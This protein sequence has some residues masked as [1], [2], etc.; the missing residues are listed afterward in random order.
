[1]VRELERKH[2]GAEFPE[3]APAANPVF[4]RTYSRRQQ[5]EG[6]RE[7][8]V[9]VCDRT[10]KGLVEL[11][12]LTHDEAVILERMQRNLK[13]LPSG[14][15]LWVGGTNWLTQPKNFSGAYNCTSTNVV[16]WSAFGLMMDLAMMGCGTGAILEPKY[17]N[18][19][20]T[21]RN[22]LKVTIRGNI[23]KTI[24]NERREF[25]ETKIE[26]DRTTIYVGDSRQGWVQS[27]QTLLELSTDER[28]TEE[29]EVIVDISDIR[30]AGEPLQGFGGMANPVKLP[31][32]YQRCAAILN[33]AVGRKLTSVECCLLIDEAAVTIVAGNIRR[34][35]AYG[36]RVS[37]IDGMKPIQDIQVGD[38]VL[39]SSG[40]YRPVVNKFIQGKQKVVEIRT[41]ITS[42]RCTAN[43]RVAVYDGL[44][45]YKWK[46]A[47]QLQ[48]K[49]RLISVPH[50]K[51]ADC[52]NI[53][54]AWLSGFYIGDGYANRRHTG[55][56]E[57][58]FALSK[59]RLEGKLGEK[60]LRIL[61][62]LG[63][64]PTIAYS[65][66]G[67]HGFIK[68]YRKE[69]AEELLKYKQPWECPVIPEFI[70]K[71]SRDI[72]AAF[73]AGLSDADGTPSRNV[74]V[75]SNKLEFLRQV[76]KL[77]LSLGIA[78]TLH[79]RKPRTIEGREKVYEGCHWIHI[80]GLQ[81]QAVVVGLIN[82]FAVRN[83]F[84][85]KLAKKN[86]LTLPYQYVK[87]LAATGWKPET[88]YSA[89]TIWVDPKSRPGYFR[90]A[91]F[92]TLIAEDLVNPHWLPIEVQFVAPA[93][94]A[95]T[96]D[97]EVEGDHEFIADGLLVHNSAGMRQGVSEDTAFADAKEN[98]WQQGEDGNWRIDPE[99]DALRMA[100]HTRVF[101]QKPTLEECVNAV[102]KQ[103][104][105]GE[106]AIQWAG[107]AVA[108]ANIDLL[109]TQELK[110]DFL[111]A[112]QQGK[113][114]YWLKEKY[115]YLD[116]SEIEHRLARAGLNPCGN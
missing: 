115:S 86:G 26:G 35:I 30:K 9:E 50:K 48:P 18:Q 4:F 10:L 47:G 75:N 101:H 80:Q 73:L 1:M 97:I 52:A 87:E 103:Y 81:S 37:A 60:C 70:W 43:H 67:N 94:Q 49:D 27:Y 79:E 77:A 93:G 15:W 36:T 106:G 2:L 39:T 65:S 44:R 45:S 113:G 78:T 31:E 12:K 3:T 23:G 34:C 98:L 108:R 88:L 54:Y 110:T 19:L 56:S 114:A 91:N 55:Q 62:N 16:D 29:V 13:A 90:D 63:Y 76:Q 41:P 51:G 22:R 61:Q 82:Q 7:T 71:G 83:E 89:N 72:R 11:G 68:V 85:I 8:W 20:P 46:Y 111:Q 59:S 66:K 92:D 38:L 116:D 100:N 105:S 14:R 21:I 33:K 109:T 95:E 104:Y 53:D 57:V 25:T 28:L 107:E 24:A 64:T 6:T 99:R 74:L 102:R 17:I 69:L 32:L 58:I 42:I 96:F 84:T 40:E 112:Y 5:P